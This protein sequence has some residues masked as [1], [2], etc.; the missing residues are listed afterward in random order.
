[1]IDETPF[2]LGG[3]IPV[4]VIG[5]V[6]IPFAS[7][8]YKFGFAI[9]VMVGVMVGDEGKGVTF[10]FGER[11]IVFNTLNSVFIVSGIDIK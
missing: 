2:V 4:I 1:M 6:I 3:A 5:T 10:A 7:I 11:F 8:V 9:V